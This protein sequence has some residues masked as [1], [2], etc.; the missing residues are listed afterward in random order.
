MANGRLPASQLATIHGGAKLD[1][2]AAGAFKVMN[3]EAVRRFG[4]HIG[5]CDAYRI[6]VA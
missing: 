4:R 1:K 2:E 3:P 5:V 6:L